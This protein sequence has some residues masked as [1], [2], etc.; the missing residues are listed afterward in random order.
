[1]NILIDTSTFGCNIALF[2]DNKILASIQEPIE[3]GHAETLVPLYLKL[4]QSINKTPQDIENIYT[5]VGPG[6][7]TGLRVSLTTA[8]FIGFSL[9]KPVYGI[10]GFQAFSAHVSGDK[11]RLVLIDTKR[12]DYYCQILD[13][14]HKQ[15]ADA[16]CLSAGNVTKL[17]DDNI[18]I[19]GDVDFEKCVKQPMINIKSVVE[20]IQSGKIELSK[21]EAFYIRDADVSQ[22]KATTL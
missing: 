1:M 10:T 14:N 19:T 15:I 22:P 6:S 5:I 12:G 3:R 17:L 13:C 21:P 11:N 18:V 4:I 20:M 16:Q 9:S 2:S 8:Q 7:F